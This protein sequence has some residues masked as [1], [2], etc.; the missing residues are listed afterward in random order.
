MSQGEWKPADHRLGAD[1]VGTVIAAVAGG[2]VIA[3]AVFM[4]FLLVLLVGYS[5]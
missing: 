2:L 5:R 1:R 3:G 4:A